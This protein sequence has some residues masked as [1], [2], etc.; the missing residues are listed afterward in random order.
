[1]LVS[2]QSVFSHLH[3]WFT[4]T[5]CSAAVSACQAASRGLC[6]KYTATFAAVRQAGRTAPSGSR[7]AWGCQPPC[8]VGGAANSSRRPVRHLEL[9]QIQHAHSLY[10]PARHRPPCY[11]APAVPLHSVAEN[12]SDVGIASHHSVC[13]ALQDLTPSATRHRRRHMHQSQRPQQA[14]QA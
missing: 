10:A 13:A 2:Q 6:W 3:A 14:C 12:C 5:S 1:M 4:A 7:I 11:P 8:S 9:P